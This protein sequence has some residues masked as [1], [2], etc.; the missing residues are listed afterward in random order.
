MWVGWILLP[1]DEKGSEIIRASNLFIKH[2]QPHA[3][4]GGYTEYEVEVDDLDK[5]DPYWG[6]AVWGLEEV[7]G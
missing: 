2:R 7:P 6:E 3:I 1:N 5:L 4:F